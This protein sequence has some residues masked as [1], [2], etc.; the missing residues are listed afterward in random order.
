LHA[1]PNFVSGP[2]EAAP[3]SYAIA[4]SAQPIRSTSDVTIPSGT[5]RTWSLQAAS[6]RDKAIALIKDA[7]QRICDVRLLLNHYD[8]SLSYK[9][10]SFQRELN[11]RLGGLLVAKFDQDAR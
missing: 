5:E 6:D 11:D 1:Q 2:P 9:L 7:R 10:D 8:T 3:Q 4:V